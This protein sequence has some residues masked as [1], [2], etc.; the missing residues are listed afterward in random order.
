MGIQEPGH[1]AR[2]SVVNDK[3]EVRLFFERNT[4]METLVER[5]HMSRDAP[6]SQL[7]DTILFVWGRSV[8]RDEIQFMLAQDASGAVIA[9]KPSLLLFVDRYKHHYGS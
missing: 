3:A 9:T 4:D 2:A 5:V 6:Q 7:L 8:Y 1:G